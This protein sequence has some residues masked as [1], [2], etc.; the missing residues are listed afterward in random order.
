[1]RGNRTRIAFEILTNALLL[2]YGYVYGQTTHSDHHNHPNT[3]GSIRISTQSSSR[4]TRV[5]PT[6]AA[7]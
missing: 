1:V 3:D 7:G 2:G 4:S 6:V 5:P